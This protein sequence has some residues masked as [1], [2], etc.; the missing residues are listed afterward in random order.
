M[1]TTKVYYNFTNVNCL[2]HPS[3]ITIAYNYSY[4]SNIFFLT[5]SS[6]T[7]FPNI[8]YAD[9]FRSL[10]VLFINIESTLQSVYIKTSPEY[11]LLQIITKFVFLFYYNNMTNILLSFLPNITIEVIWR[12][13]SFSQT[14]I[15]W[16][17]IESLRLLCFPRGKTIAWLKPLDRLRGL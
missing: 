15:Y 7:I 1:F 14:H 6:E 17:E 2:S 13:S 3:R 12:S 11:F 4:F 10:F 5:V 9:A 16:S 8:E